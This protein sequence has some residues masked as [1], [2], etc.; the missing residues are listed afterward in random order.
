MSNRPT[1]F[2]TAVF[3]LSAA[4]ERHAAT[5][6]VLEHQTSTGRV[7]AHAPHVWPPL[8][9]VLRR[10]HAFEERG[11]ARRPNRETPIAGAPLLLMVDGGFDQHFEDGSTAGRGGAF[12]GGPRVT[13]VTM[14][15]T[16][17][18]EGVQIDLT[19][20]GARLLFGAP[21]V[22]LRDAVFQ[23]DDVFGAFAVRLRGRLEAAGGW[24]ERFALIEAALVERLKTAQGVDARA[25]AAAWAIEGSQGR[26]RIAALAHET[27]LSR[28][29]LSKLMRTEFGLRPKEAADL[30]RFDAS[31]RALRDEPRLGL[32]EAAQ[33]FGYADQSHLTRAFRTFGGAPPTVLRRR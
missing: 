15:A 11:A 5:T 31:L 18:Y 20:L 6:I 22:E 1:P 7:V 26:L 28:G 4:R 19:L 9:G 32:A 27:G 8:S 16:G 3:D 2:E 23:L 17:D 25:A 33:R 10:M 29:R 14:A 12:G 21:L 13:P 24:A 30:A